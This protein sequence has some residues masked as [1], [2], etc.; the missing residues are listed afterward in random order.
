MKSRLNALKRR[1]ELG[2]K[3]IN[4]LRK[5]RE[6]AISNKTN[7]EQKQAK[8]ANEQ[9]KQIQELEKRKARIA[10]LRQKTSEVRV[11]MQ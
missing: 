5:D 11:K 9:A 1:N 7:L 6:D 3:R 2:Q 10:D 8:K 4:S